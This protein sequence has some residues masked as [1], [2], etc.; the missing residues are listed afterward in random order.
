MFAE[1]PN[2]NPPQDGAVLWRYMDFTKFVS[3]LDRRALYFSRADK[4][5]DPFEGSL[6]HINRLTRPQWLTES[7]VPEEVR[8]QILEVAPSMFGMV[9]RLGLVNCWHGNNYE[10]EAMWKL[11]AGKQ[12][13]IA[14]KTTFEKLAGSLECEDEIYIGK[15]NYVDYDT[16][17]I[18]EGNILAILL[19]K[20][21][22]F[23]HEREI[24]AIALNSL[25]SEQD[26][27]TYFQVNLST[28]IGE[29]LVAPQ[30]PEWFSELVNSIVIRYKLKVP[31]RA[32]TLS[33]APT[34]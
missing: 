5:G 13:G 12:S 16:T 22:S 28:L 7:G 8:E 14:I 24:R 34:W 23:E 26:V 3:L 29:V 1:H 10:S 20:R 32:S 11:Y 2:L 17:F 25:S 9:P 6:S 31:V 30:A 18:P 27:G 4:L 21:K 15:V 19:N 33:A